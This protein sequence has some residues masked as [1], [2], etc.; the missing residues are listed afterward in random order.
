MASLLRVLFEVLRIK[1][2]RQPVWGSCNLLV[3][4]MKPSPFSQTMKLLE[5]EPLNR[6]FL[7]V[8]ETLNSNIPEKERR[9]DKIPKSINSLRHASKWERHKE[10]FH[11][12]QEVR[13]SLHWYI[14]CLIKKK[15]KGE[16]KKL[17]RFTDH[18]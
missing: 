3:S 4:Y 16:R 17:V 14:V 15:E 10:E 2:Y 11:L 1:P 5:P 7:S 9:Q 6:G 13:F 12:N 18:L 8:S